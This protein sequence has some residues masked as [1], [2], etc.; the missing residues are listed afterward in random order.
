VTLTHKFTSVETNIKKAQPS[1]GKT[2]YS[3]YNSCYSTRPSRSSKVDD[4]HLNWKG[5]TGVCRFLGPI[6]H[7]FRDMANF[8]L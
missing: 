1:L 8:R 6:S 3:L 4:F 2:R 5:A 7:C